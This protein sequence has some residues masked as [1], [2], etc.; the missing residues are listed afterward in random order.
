MREIKFRIWYVEKMQYPHIQEV[1]IGRSNQITMQYTGLKDKNGKEIYEGDIVKKS[2]AKFTI[3]FF[4]MI[5][6]NIISVT[7]ISFAYRDLEIIGNIYENPE[8]LKGNEK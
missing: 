4:E 5:G 7:R 6:I 8:L 3:E 1:F 2:R